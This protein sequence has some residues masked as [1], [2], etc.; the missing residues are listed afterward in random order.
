MEGRGDRPPEIYG[1]PSSKDGQS[2]SSGEGGL[3]LR[4]VQRKRDEEKAR[5]AREQQVRGRKDSTQQERPGLWV[6]G[7]N[8]QKYRLEQLKKAQ[9]QA[10][11]EENWRNHLA[12]GDSEEAKPNHSNQHVHNWLKNYTAEPRS[13]VHGTPVV[14]DPNRPNPLQADV[15]LP[16][17]RP[18]S[19]RLPSPSQEDWHRQSSSR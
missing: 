1:Y 9:A 3:V 5:R 2:K 15:D 18:P 19:F 6:G 12:N 4:T 16:P 14:F 17:S 11:L 10:E 13:Y 8:A 7:D